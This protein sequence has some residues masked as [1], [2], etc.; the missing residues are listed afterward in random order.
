MKRAATGGTYRGPVGL[1]RQ[2]RTIRFVQLLLVLV[3]LSL[4]AFSIYSFGAGEAWSQGVAG[5]LLTV[6]AGAAAGL[7]SDGRDVRIPTP[8]RLDELAGRAERVAIERA[9]EG[10]GSS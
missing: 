3:A 8:A 7:L 5:V 1:R 9:E 10:A 6:V 4:L 2:K